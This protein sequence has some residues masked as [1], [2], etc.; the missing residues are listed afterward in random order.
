MVVTL[1][2]KGA[3]LLSLHQPSGGQQAGSAAE[4]HRVASCSPQ[5][6]AQLRLNQ[7]LQQQLS[8][9]CCCS[10]LSMHVAYMPALPAKVVS[11]SGAGGWV[12][13]RAWQ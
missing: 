10:C 7:P 2:A 5:P 9:E 4:R 1:G 3:A 13:N 6:H 11:L 12:I 8:D